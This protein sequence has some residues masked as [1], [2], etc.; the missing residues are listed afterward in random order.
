[1]SDYHVVS[2]QACHSVTFGVSDW[3]REGRRLVICYACGQVLIE[4]SFEPQFQRRT[5]PVDP[6]VG[7][8]P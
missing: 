8:T 2:C 1:M 7:G 6:N 3:P 5:T 4:L